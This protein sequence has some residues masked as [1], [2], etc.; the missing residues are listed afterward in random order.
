MKKIALMTLIATAMSS[1]AF[2]QSAEIPVHAQSW[3]NT[4]Q[5]LRVISVY[6]LTD[7]LLKE[8]MKGE[9]PEIAVEFSA[10]S[11]LPISFFLKGDVATFIEND[12]N[13]QYIEI[14]QTF[15]GRCIK[16]DEP[17]FSSNL[18]DWKP[19]LEFITGNASVALS[20]QDGNEGKPSII[21]GSEINKRS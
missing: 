3:G 5:D 6:D 15:Y 9:H 1:I 2:P 4:S 8:I 17:F 14:K 11:F 13:C 10:H 12:R 7:Q 19:L 21:I 18:K 16:K 20:I